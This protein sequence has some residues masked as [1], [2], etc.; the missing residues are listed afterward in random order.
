M[1]SLFLFFLSS[2]LSSPWVL[3][4]PPLTPTIIQKLPLSLYSLSLS[5]LLSLFS[6]P[7]SRSRSLTR[8]PFQASQD[9]EK[10][11]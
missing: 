4:P 2:F 11:A 6:R 5:L 7:R 9:A 8:Q 3:P 10:R 1:C